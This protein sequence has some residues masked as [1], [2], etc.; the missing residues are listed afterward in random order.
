ML[1][2]AD[3][4]LPPKLAY[5]ANFILHFAPFALCKFKAILKIADMEIGKVIRALRNTRGASL[6]SLAFD[7][8]TDA[9]NL[10]RIERGV[11][12]PTEDGLRA[13]ASA[14]GTT[15]ATL[16][17][18]AEGKSLVDARTGG[19]LDLDD[20]GHESV[21]MRRYFKSL[22]PEYRKVAFELVKTLARIQR[23]P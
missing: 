1:V 6:E 9:S 4:S 3:Y 18:T 11:Q 5:Y 10:S 19:T 21:Q 17:A 13:I 16:Y 23:K 2:I 20:L 22:T 8:G 7:A 12:K 14:L 15:I